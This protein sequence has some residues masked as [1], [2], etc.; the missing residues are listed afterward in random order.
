M[1]KE[2]NY[3]AL[4]KYGQNFLKDP[5]IIS[6]IVN[7][8]NYEKNDDMSSSSN[9]DNFDD[10]LDLCNKTILSNRINLHEKFIR[11]T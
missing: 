7:I 4:K 8:V 5:N 2:N 3:K 6:K 11:I 9:Q 10:D 1:N